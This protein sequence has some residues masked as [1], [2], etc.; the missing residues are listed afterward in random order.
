MKEAQLEQ[1]IHYLANERQLSPH[2]LDNYTRD[3]NRFFDFTEEQGIP[4]WSSVTAKQVRQFAAQIHR[5]GLAGKSIQRSL[6][7]LRSFFR[8]LSREGVVDQN[9]ADAVQAPKS[10][11]KLPETLDV[12]QIDR[13]LD[14]PVKDAVSARDS[15]IMELIY[16]SGLRI[17][18]LVGLD[19][20]SLDL[21]DH[22]LRVLGK[23]NKQRELP[24]GRKALQAIDRWL[25][26]RHE[27]ASFDENALFVSSRG[28]RISVRTVQ[29]RMYHWGKYL[30]VNGHVHP[31]R[32]RHSFASHMLESS[33][34][35]RAVQELLGHEDISTT[36]IYTHL[37]FQHLMQVYEG[38]HPRA[39]KK[40]K[41]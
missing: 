17:S 37:D 29:Q 15:A 30:E 26:Y 14:I 39:H 40:G 23:G 38:A 2:T 6:S 11:R 24:I 28:K 3:I 25:D 4:A 41:K 36:Q 10:Q 21:A 16:S 13:L 33:G 1:F 22:S 5:Q 34:D 20:H 7:A 12:D 9:P 27:L 35:L 8:F 31:H 32:L 18:E 19:I